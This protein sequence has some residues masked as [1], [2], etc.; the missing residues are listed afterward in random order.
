[1]RAHT[2]GDA[3]RYTHSYPYSTDAAPQQAA[4]QL[5]PYVPGNPPEAT[6]SREELEAIV[7]SDTAK[8]TAQGLEVTLREAVRV[9]HED[10][11]QQGNRLP[12]GR[13]DKVLA[14]WISAVDRL[15]QERGVTNLKQLL[16]INKVAWWR[17]RVPNALRTALNGLLYHNARLPTAIA[18]RINGLA[19]SPPQR[20]AS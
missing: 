19:A 9:I 3:G 1:M 20:P 12:S 10:Y 5:T 15:E 14:R 4:P 8:L 13:E 16:E 18:Q 2:G 7:Y 17:T 6:Y 11:A